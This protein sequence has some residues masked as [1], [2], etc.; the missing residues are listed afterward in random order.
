[1]YQAFPFQKFGVG[2]GRVLSVS[3]TV[4]APEEV[5]MPGLNLTEPVFRV[6]VALERMDI[7]AYGQSIPLQAGM[8][9]SADIVVERRNLLEWLF[10]PLYAAGRRS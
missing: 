3:R 7:E 5:A 9:L 8:T 6:R 2:R 1:M 10:D 4:L